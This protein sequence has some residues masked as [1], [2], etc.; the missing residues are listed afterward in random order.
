MWL[1]CRSHTPIAS[2]ERNGQARKLICTGSNMRNLKVMWRLAFTFSL[3]LALALLAVGAAVLGMRDLERHAATLE[4]ENAALLTAAAALQAGGPGHAEAARRVQPLLDASRANAG[5]RSSTGRDAV[6]R[7]QL[8]VAAVV[9]FGVALGIAATWAVTR[10]IVR[11]LHFAARTAERVAQGDLRRTVQRGYRDETGRVVLALGDMQDK[12]NTLVRAIRDSAGSVHAAA[13]RI[14]GSNTDLAARTDEQAAA[15][16]Q[17]AANVEELTAIVTR[18]TEGAGT[19]SD[20]AREAC[21]L[22]EGSGEAVTGVVQRMQQIVK[23]SRNVSD[24]VGVMD[25]IAFQTNLLALNAAVEAARAG[26]QGRGFAVVAAQVRVLAQRSA[27]AARD[28]KTLVNEAVGEA[29]HGAR[30]ARQAGESMAGV[31]RVVR[32][33]ARLVTEIA[34]AS[35]EQRAGI[36]QVNTT[37]GHMDAGTQSN[38]GLVQEINGYTRLLLAQ[39]SELMVAASRFRLDDGDAAAPALQDARAPAALA[40]RPV[41]A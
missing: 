28:I 9:A 5:E 16:Q 22:A 7:A 18:N 15:L 2:R 26:E 13:E 21:A 37:V 35:E 41:S 27:E 39:A 20:L 11:P 32:E 36:Q 14:S 30:A 4:R 33:V 3:L 24:I 6:R 40:W 23:A 12:L 10:G 34:R 25:E 1:W 38:A 31:V 29:D 19:A 17:T 8:L